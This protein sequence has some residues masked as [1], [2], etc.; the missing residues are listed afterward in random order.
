MYCAGKDFSP[1]SLLIR[2][3]LSLKYILFIKL[4]KL[5][6]TLQKTC[7]G[8]WGNCVCESKVVRRKTAKSTLGLWESAGYDLF[9]KRILWQRG[10]KCIS[11]FAFL[12]TLR[13]IC[14][15]SANTQFSTFSTI[16][17]DSGVTTYT[18]SYT[19]NLIED[20][21]NEQC[22]LRQVTHLHVALILCS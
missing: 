3:N 10:K 7:S 16:L 8:I 13:K 15:Q 21:F 18:I 9:G 2:N 17:F 19:L 11:T 20:L 4:L 6:N 22:P 12:K 1:G 14:K 5:L